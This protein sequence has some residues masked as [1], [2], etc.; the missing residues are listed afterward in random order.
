[1]AA[2]MRSNL[3]GI[4]FTKDDI[5]R[6]RITLE[7]E[8]FIR[9]IVIIWCTLPCQSAQSRKNRAAKIAVDKEW[10]TS[11][12]LP[13]WNTSKIKTDKTSS[14][15]QE[16]TTEKNFTTLMHLCRQKDVELAE[17][18]KT[19][20]RTKSLSTRDSEWTGYPTCEHLLPVEQGETPSRQLKPKQLQ[21]IQESSDVTI[22][23]VPFASHLSALVFFI[24]EA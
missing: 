16:L 6:M 9:G 21:T 20:R 13:A 14:A 2:W 10:E 11:Q 3:K 24:F 5:L 4:S 15:K 12:I 17:H 8:D 18:T 7:I 22:P 1:M 23:T 19:K